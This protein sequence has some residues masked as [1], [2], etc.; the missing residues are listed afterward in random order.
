MKS[1]VQ[2][3]VRSYSSTP[4]ITSDT[5][6]SEEK[7]DFNAEISNSNVIPEV[8][9]N[10]PIPS[11]VAKHGYVFS[12]N[13]QNCDMDSFGSLWTSFPTDKI[14][15]L[16]RNDSS[17]RANYTINSLVNL[18]NSSCNQHPNTQLAIPGKALSCNKTFSSLNFSASILSQSSN[19]SSYQTVSSST[20]W[21]CIGSPYVLNIIKRRESK[22]LHSDS[23][24]ILSAQARVPESENQVKL[25]TLNI[26]EVIAHSPSE[27]S[28]LSIHKGK[29]HAVQITC[30]GIDQTGGTEGDRHGLAGLNSFLMK[31][32][33]ASRDTSVPTISPTISEATTHENFSLN[34]FQGVPTAKV[35][36]A[37]D[38]VDPSP[39][40]STQ[41]RTKAATVSFAEGKIKYTASSKNM[42]SAYPISFQSFSKGNQYHRK[43]SMGSE[44]T[45]EGGYAACAKGMISFRSRGSNYSW[46]NIGSSIG[47][48]SYSFGYVTLS[49][50]DTQSLSMYP[51]PPYN[52]PSVNIT[53]APDLSSTTPSDLSV[54]SDDD[55]IASAPDVMNM[56][57]TNAMRKWKTKS[58][59][60]FINQYQILE[61]IGHGT[62][63]KV[64]LA[65]DT[66]HTRLV[67]LK[68]VLRADL[69]RRLGGPTQAQL[70]YESFMREVSVMKRLRHRN[71]VHL[72]E[73]IDDPNAEELYLV[74][75]YVDRG[76]IADIKLSDNTDKV[77]E[78]IPPSQLVQVVRQALAGLEYL[79]RHNVVHRD[80]KPQNILM[81]SNG[82]LYLS[83]FGLAE[84]FDKQSLQRMH[85]IMEQSMVQSK[86][87]CVTE[88]H[89]RVQKIWGVKGTMLFLA[90]EVWKGS[91]TNGKP[92]DIWAMGV[93]L[94]TL[95]TGRLP[96]TTIDAVRDPTKPVIPTE[97]GVEWTELLKGM[98]EREP[99]KR[100]TV[101]QAR[102]QV[103]KL[104]NIQGK[105]NST[106]ELADCTPNEQQRKPP[107]E[108]TSENNRM[109]GFYSLR[110]FASPRSPAEQGTQSACLAPMPQP[111]PLSPIK[112]SLSTPPTSGGPIPETRPVIRRRCQRCRW[113]SL[114][115]VGSN[116][117]RLP[118]ESLTRTSA[119]SVGEVDML[120]K[121]TGD[122]RVPCRSVGVSD[123]TSDENIGNKPTGTLLSSFRQIYPS[124]RSD[125]S[126]NLPRVQGTAQCVEKTTT[127]PHSSHPSSCMY[128]IGLLRE[129][130]NQTSTLSSLNSLA[131]QPS[132]SK[133]SNHL[134]PIQTFPS[135]VLTKP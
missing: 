9:Q 101:S 119:R 36:S 126:L 122:P 97:Y 71:I 75:Q 18:S 32:E 11:N 28:S 52:R 104:I 83:D 15:I 58:G 10:A 46:R 23:E 48:Q 22:D 57:M 21:S 2:T 14:N 13:T 89:A 45:I 91:S 30:A 120:E 63:A 109:R 70:N 24:K 34:D 121:Q 130:K 62:S 123:N 40:V 61:G 5:L 59:L 100:M 6:T 64:K 39:A 98:L 49:N 50:D 110:K 132:W 60:R 81:D 127:D 67:A 72:Y 1:K 113:L 25:Q 105:Q 19:S 69:K 86:D 17:W 125:V 44:V 3:H 41:Q 103:K 12:S 7:R 16:K 84:V 131:L 87:L 133:V 77:C 26:P 128:N 51:V 74:M 111:G 78:P 117:P 29:R 76:V 124:P 114:C 82:V 112:R 65:Y 96:F 20:A 33:P 54:N 56:C 35:A 8:N 27:F 134:P 118:F 115:S 85:H 66:V 79:H 47:N 68:E 4:S 31:R 129:P 38:V 55:S 107:K 102:L 99:K 37:T 116:L 95:L 73:V 135:N 90:P 53:Q 93:T 42:Q 43:R 106:K 80:I 108:I 88:A 92:V 94:F